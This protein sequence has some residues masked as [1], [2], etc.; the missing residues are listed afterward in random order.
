MASIPTTGK[1][2]W[3]VFG[4]PA[5]TSV[6]DPANTYELWDDFLGNTL[7][8][9]KWSLAAG[10]V[11]VADSIMNLANINT[12]VR[13]IATYPVG[14]AV[15]ANIRFSNSATSLGYGFGNASY[16]MRLLTTAGQFAV[17]SYPTGGDW[18]QTM[19]SGLTMQYAVYDLAKYS[20]YGARYYLNNV[21][22]DDIDNGE[23]V[24]G[25]VPVEMVCTSNN[26]G[27]A[28]DWIS[29]RK[30]STT[31]PTRGTWGAKTEIITFA[32]MTKYYAQEQINL[33]DSCVNPLIAVLKESILLSDTAVRSI[34]TR[35]VRE[36]IYLGDSGK[37]MLMH[38]AKEVIK[39]GNVAAGA[40]VAKETIYLHNGDDPQ[41]QGCDEYGTGIVDEELD[42]YGNPVFNA[43][44]AV[45]NIIR[46]AIHY[47]TDTKCK[48]VTDLAICKETVYISNSAEENE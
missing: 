13:S 27:L 33:G 40:F 39:L 5:S 32:D 23:N 24:P 34:H 48:V 36:V 30:C 43:L 25:G 11:T 10:G 6:S 41:A 31:E 35:V 17:R 16:F 9:A 38:L 28:F 21:F 12:V 4:D 7:D 26:S 2:M 47:K 46:K 19:V 44:N 3:V 45:G 14:R 18:T 29:V 42:E 20:A 1:T 37:G 8:T 22:Y 15:R